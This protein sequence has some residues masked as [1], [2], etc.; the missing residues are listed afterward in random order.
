ML[1]YP[2]F[3]FFLKQKGYDFNIKFKDESLFMKILGVLVWIY[4]K[5]FMSEYTTVIGK[6]IYFPS[7]KWVDEDQYSLPIIIAHEMVHMQDKKKLNSYFPGLYSFLYLAPQILALLSLF[8]FFAFINI[9]F[10]FCLLFLIFLLPIPSPGRSW[11]EAR[12]YAMNLYVEEYLFGNSPT[13]LAEYVTYYFSGSEYYFMWPFPNSVKNKLLENYKNAEKIA[14][15][16]SDF[17]EWFEK[18]RPRKL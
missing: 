12:G 8:A 2:S 17:S 7:R 1:G 6:T 3:I 9:N 18:E 16:F 10:L 14:P 11:I 5:R 13:F 15:I 4:N